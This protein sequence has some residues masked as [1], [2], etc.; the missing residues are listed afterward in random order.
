M[1]PIREPARRVV[2]KDEQLM[3]Q[4]GTAP[5]ELYRGFR[6]KKRAALEKKKKEEEELKQ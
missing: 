3:E 4:F 5:D 1:A 6:D 2:S